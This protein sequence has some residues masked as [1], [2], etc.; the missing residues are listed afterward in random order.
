MEEELECLKLASVC[1]SENYF[2]FR[3]KFS[4]KASG[5]EKE[6]CRQTG[7]EEILAVINIKRNRNL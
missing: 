4:K 2:T 6:T 3:G 5:I 7:K 1:V